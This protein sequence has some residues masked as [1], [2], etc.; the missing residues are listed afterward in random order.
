MI[1]DFFLIV[2]YNLFRMK[3][4]FVMNRNKII[5]SNCPNFYRIKN[6]EFDENDYITLKIIGIYEDYIFSINE[7]SEEELKK[8][9]ELDSILG[10]YID[11]YNFRKEMQ[12][13]LLNLKVK[14]GTNITDIIIDSLLSLYDSYEDGYT[15]NIYF[16]RWI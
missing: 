2:Y 6:Y 15:R 1:I 8:C 7:Q 9:K 3:G 12:R 11:D 10:K 4:S 14:R 13:G 16:A 5:L